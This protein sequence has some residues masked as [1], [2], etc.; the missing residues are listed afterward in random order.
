MRFP[1]PASFELVAS[2]PN[3]SVFHV[4]EGQREGVRAVAKRLLPRVREEPA[5]KAAMVREASFLAR[6]RHRAVPALL[7][8]G[9][10]AHGPFVVEGFVEGASLRAL[11]DA[12]AA[13]GLAVPGPLLLHVAREAFAA[14]A[15][16]HDLTADGAPLGLCHGDLGPDHVILSATGEIGFVDFGAA[17][18]ADMKPDL[19]T[20]DRGTL[21]FVAPEVA[22]GEHKPDAAA[23]VYA[24]AASLLFVA[25]RGR[26][27]PQTEA[28]AMLLA[29]GERGLP[30]DLAD[31][32]PGPIRN[33]LRYAIPFA[34]AERVTSAREILATFA[35]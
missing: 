4:A 33:A 19:E 10:D 20:D 29:V 32:L 24:L 27:L 5:A 21:P 12:W 8:V 6:A 35:S 11:V 14:L 3:G 15:D 18:F 23:D 13:R 22:R 25:N 34:R 16:V 7:E 9:A 17:R 1:A 28:A 30:Q 26:L 31:A 2:L